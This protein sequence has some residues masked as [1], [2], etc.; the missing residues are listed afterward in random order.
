LTKRRIYFAKHFS[1]RIS[2]PTPTLLHRG[3]T[4]GVVLGCV[5]FYLFYLL[6]LKKLKAEPKGPI[7]NSLFKVNNFFLVQISQQ[8]GPCFCCV[9]NKQ[10]LRTYHRKSYIP[11]RTFIF[12]PLLMHLSCFRRLIPSSGGA[13]GRLDAAAPRSSQRHHPPVRPPPSTSTFAPLQAYCLHTEERPSPSHI[14]GED[15]MCAPLSCPSPL[16]ID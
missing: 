11:L 12:F 4:T 10:K 5:W 8:V 6:L 13:P 14:T 3:A 2:A 15:L 7:Q 1:K 16:F 9:L